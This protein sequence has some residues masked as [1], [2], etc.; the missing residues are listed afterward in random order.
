MK[1]NSLIFVY[2]IICVL[3]F[4]YISLAVPLPFPPNISIKDIINH[5]KRAIEKNRDDK[6]NQEDYEKSQ[7]NFNK[8]LNNKDLEV[9]NQKNELRKKFN[10]NWSGE[11]V[12]KKENQL[13]ISCKIKILIENYEGKFKSKC[14]NV[15]IEMYLFI[16]I[17]RNLENS[18][19]LIPLQNKKFELVGDITSFGGNSPDT[20]VR[21]NLKK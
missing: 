1:S 3:F 20:Y 15:N 16:N 2:S 5:G 11:L 10:G 9:L 12:I 18:F 14:E 7:E 13:N 6:K 19:V 4:N 8:E 17:D 21:G